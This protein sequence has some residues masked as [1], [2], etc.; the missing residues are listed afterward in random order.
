MLSMFR[1]YLALDFPIYLS[2][3]EPAYENSQLCYYI[4]FTHID[5]VDYFKLTFDNEGI[6]LINYD[7]PLGT[8]RNFLFVVI[9]GIFCLEEFLKKKTESFFH[10]AQKQAEWLIKNVSYEDKR[11]YFWSVDFPW[12]EGGGLIKPPWVS[13]MGQGMALSFLTRICK[14]KKFDLP[15]QLFDNALKVF[16][17]GINN[18]GVRYEKN[19]SVFFEEYCCIPPVHVLD[20]FLVSLL[21]LHD[22]YKYADSKKAKQLFS[23][24]VGCLEREIGRWN[25]NNTWS[26]YYPGKK[27]SDRMYNKLNASLL[28]EL[29]RITGIKAFDKMANCWS[30]Y[31]KTI[32]QKISIYWKWFEWRLKHNRQERG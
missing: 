3:D 21:G 6:P 17:I 5:L 12:V 25:F 1:N 23:E 29:Y 13:A 24:G 14:V 10:Q 9:W 27:L 30:P 16:E 32:S 4:D 8:Q 2:K 28:S 22:T 19:G 31:K 26:W 18:G 15:Q 11:G 20:G 7:L